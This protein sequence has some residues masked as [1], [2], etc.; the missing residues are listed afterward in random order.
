MSKE[1]R[2]KKK[3][4]TSLVMLALGCSV[5]A[6]E[7]TYGKVK[8]L[9][10]ADRKSEK[11]EVRMSFEQDEVTVQQRK[12]RE[13][14]FVMAYTEIDG[15]TYSKSA[16]PRWKTGLATMAALGPYAIPFFFMKGKKHW[17][18]VKCGGEMMA[19]RLDKRNYNMIIAELEAKTGRQAH[20]VIE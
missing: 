3:V 8:Y 18:T 20:R 4:L 17:L 11:I 13:T 12:T 16:H 5:L 15:F 6:D 10:A 7:P 14:L 1:E 19:F 9:K 2:M